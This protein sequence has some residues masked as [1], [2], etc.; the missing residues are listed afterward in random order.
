MKKNI[1]YI[2]FLSLVI[3][4]LSCST[5]KDKWANRKYHSIT[6]HYN[7]LWNGQEA[8]KEGKRSIDQAWKDDYTRILPIYING[9]NE[10]AVAI[11]GNTDR[12]IEK[13]GKVI[14]T[15]SM[16]F[17]GIEKN[18][19]IDDA[20]LLIGKACY[21][22]HDY[23]AAE[24]SFQYII[25]NWKN[26]QEIYQPM[27][28]LSLTYCKQKKHAEAEIVLKQVLKAIEEGKAP[29]KLKKML[30]LV[31]AENDIA[32]GKTLSALQHLQLRKKNIF[33]RKLNTRTKFIEGQIYMNNL[34]YAQASKC[35]RY[36]ARH[37]SD[38]S[39]QFVSQLNI[40]LC[41]DPA[42]KNSISII[43]DLEK[44]LDDNKNEEYLDQIYYAIGEVYYRNKSYT[45]ACKKWEESVKY[46]KTNKVQK[47]ASALRAANIYYDT[48]QNYVKAQLYYDTALSLMD[49]DYPHRNIIL[50]RQ[51]VLTS[52]VENLNI[53]ERW[54]SLLALSELSKEELD[55]KIEKW[56]TDYKIEKKR[57]EEEAKIQQAILARNASM[58]NYNQMN[59]NASNFYFNNP[60]TVQ[61]GKIEFQRKWGDRALEDNWRLMAKQEIGFEEDSLSENLEQDSVSIV[62]NSKIQ[63][64]G[65]TPDMKE[66]Y[67]KDIPFS[68]SAKDSANA[69]IADALLE[70]GYIFFQGVDNMARSIET[71]IDLLTR[72]PQHR[73]VLPAC[74]HLYRLYDQR[75]DYPN[76]NFYKNKILSEFPESEYAEMI[77]NPDYLK[78]IQNNNTLAE[79]LY[80]EVY[81]SY[82][83]NEYL[84]TIEKGD[85]AIDSLK[86]GEYIPRLKFL[87]ALSKG[88]LYGIDSLA[89]NLNMIIYN[90]PN[91]EVT[92]IIE[93]QLRFLS[94]EYNVKDFDIKYD[95]TKASNKQENQID[96]TQTLP[97]DST[98]VTNAVNRDDILDAES[99]VYRSKDMQHYYLIFFDDSKIDM[100][101]MEKIIKDFNTKDY[102]E[103]NLQTTSQLF[104]LSDQMIIVRKFKN[105]QEALAYYDSIQEDE[106]FSKLSSSYY[107]HCVISLQNYSTLYN[108]RN[109]EAYLKYFR[110]MYLKDRETIE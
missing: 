8:L 58:S 75:G 3:L 105:R 49:K 87:V 47:M 16:R 106:E 53:I 14:K 54:D 7:A 81:Q 76:S 68:Q 29:K 25:A 93:R 88:K 94:E 60:T 85:N 82:S 15:H 100:A 1:R 84:A 23:K 13:G 51:R 62:E 33:E 55:A 95:S 67:T 78:D 101:Y 61:S 52:L 72:Y 11:K 70:A 28:W 18:P 80:R 37:A 31:W 9:T 97:N 27:L 40:A 39:M 45:I 59:R 86:A 36:T 89:D 109:I 43:E 41:F 107:R 32:Q 42:K 71:F 38:Y 110:L 5:H 50:S 103:A 56:I 17:S 35:F 48:L 10:Q 98:E 26:R 22:A 104:T 74:Y 65:Y 44:M 24:A 57:K 102:S 2:A 30:Y 19:Q 21:Y 63:N 4:F 6:A 20:Y 69:E 91:S 108:R 96:I 73:N 77:K 83:Q 90:H 12:A 66:Y 92:P 46:S 99:L 64:T 79:R 34:Q